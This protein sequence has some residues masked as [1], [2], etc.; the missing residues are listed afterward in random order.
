[1][2]TIDVLPVKL[3][4][5]NVYLIPWFYVIYLSAL[6][7][8]F[9]INSCRDQSTRA[10]LL[11]DLIR[12][13][14]FDLLSIQEVWGGASHV[15]Q[16]GL[17]KEYRLMYESWCGIMGSGWGADVVN[18]Y[19]NDRD[20]TGGLFTAVLR[21]SPAAPASIRLLYFKHH[22]FQSCAGEEFMY[23]SFNVSVLEVGRRWGDPEMKLVVVN[24]HLYSPNPFADVSR[25]RREQRGEILAALEGLPAALA[26]LSVGMTWSKCGVVLVGDLNTAYLKQGV[27]VVVSGGVGHPPRIDE[28]TEDY[29]ETLATFHARDLFL[30]SSEG[31]R[32]PRKRSYD[33]DANPY[34]SDK[35]KPD[36]ARMDYLLALDRLP[37]G[38]QLMRLKASRF[39]IHTETV[40]SDHYPLFVDLVPM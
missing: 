5:A 34:V 17:Q 39:E 35:A 14:S 21:P 36:S 27:P 26:R 28:I 2:T 33:G 11:V 16:L 31:K 6:G 4:C 19:F 10:K 38:T 20:K 15:L 3:L 9:A 29:L 30:E 18:A 24:T 22:V 25:T 23:K 1:M 40:V 32:E 7:D 13:E 8:E 12:R 37:G